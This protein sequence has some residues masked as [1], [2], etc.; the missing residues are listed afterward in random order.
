ML[1]DPVAAPGVASA[2]GSQRSHAPASLQATTAGGAPPHKGTPAHAQALRGELQR[3]VGGVTRGRNRLSG[4][5]VEAQRH[6]IW[7]KLANAHGLPFASWESFCLSPQPCGLGYSAGAI[8]AI[9]TERKDPRR[10]AQTAAVLVGHGQ[11][12]SGRSELAGTAV[13][14][15]GTGTDYYVARIKRDHPA[16]LQAL[17]EGR[18]ASVYEAA[19]SCGLAVPQCYCRLTPTSFAR[20]AL[21]YLGAAGVA[22]LVELLQHPERIAHA[23]S[24]PPKERRQAAVA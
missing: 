23:Q 8:E 9:V 12:R 24:R 18:Y 21:K 11:R 7:T 3:L 5:L 10:R 6:V 22:S 20:Q 1:L 16:V 15:G 19:L 17:Q 13:P 2:H 14:R 4:L